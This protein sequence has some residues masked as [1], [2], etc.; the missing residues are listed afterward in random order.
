[1]HTVVNIKF[2]KLVSDDF[3]DQLT[4]LDLLKLY[5]FLSFSLAMVNH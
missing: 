2:G 3:V 4:S 1:L 5:S